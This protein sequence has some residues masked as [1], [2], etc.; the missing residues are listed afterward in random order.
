LDAKVCTYFDCILVISALAQGKNGSLSPP[1]RNKLFTTARKIHLVN[2]HFNKNP[3][4]KAKTKCVQCQF[5]N[6]KGHEEDTYHFKLK[7]MQEA[8]RKTKQKAQQ[9]PKATSSEAFA[10]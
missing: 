5:C 1:L 7:A 2:N 4:P 3:P 10:I 8:Q 6:V 9:K